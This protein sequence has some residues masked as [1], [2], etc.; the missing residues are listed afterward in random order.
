MTSC[1]GPRCLGSDFH[2][3]P[4]RSPWPARKGSQT[5]LVAEGPFSINIHVQVRFVAYA[6]FFF[7]G[8][9]HQGVVSSAERHWWLGR[10]I[11]N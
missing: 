6:T 2:P 8:L 1:S 3:G 7:T 10:D 11:G 4:Q 9:E 5:C